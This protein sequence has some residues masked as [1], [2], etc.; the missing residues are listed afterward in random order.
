VRVHGETAPRD[1]TIGADGAE[2]DASG[3]V[4]VP[5]LV[6][7]TCDP[8]FPGF[9]PREDLASLSAAALAG[10]FGDLLAGPQVDPV[11]D[12][13]EDIE[14]APRSGPGGVRLWHAGA[15]TVGLDGEELAEIGLMAAAGAAAVSDGGKPIRDTVV[16]RN[17][18]EYARGFGLRVFLRPADADLD[19]LGVVHES[20]VAAELGVRGNPGAAEEIGV[21]RIVSLVRATGAAVHLT[22]VG[23]ARGTALVRAARAEGLPVTASTSARALLLDETALLARPYDT[24]LRLHPPLRSPTD[25]A[26]L[27]AGV[28]DGTL[29]LAADHA[30]RAPEEKDL[31]FERAAPGSTGLETAF[32]AALQALDGDLDTLVRAFCLGPRALLPGRPDGWTLVDA[33]ARFTVAASA[34]RS[35]A[36]NDAL[37]GIGLRGVVCACFPA[38]T[39]G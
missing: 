4:L 27:L 25:R 28:R 17:A 1:V 16:L 2:L 33:D 31:E 8:G 29:L 9:P 14:A 26:A 6:D 15:V 10:G 35:R 32:A 39:L 24:R 22:H 7:L 21:A 20:G 12:T 30:P 19:R 11:V 5:S 34:H 37:D 38:A 13:P 23:T 3:L 18:L 36:R